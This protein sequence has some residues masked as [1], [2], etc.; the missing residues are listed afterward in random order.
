MLN[1]SILKMFFFLHLGK[2]SLD[3][4]ADFSNSWARAPT[5]FTLMKGNAVWDYSLDYSHSVLSLA[6]YIYIY[7]HTHTHT[8]TYIYIYIYIYIYKERVGVYKIY[9][10]ALL[11]K[12]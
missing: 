11:L 10:V 1:V 6:V 8:H 7:T 3:S 9:D 4:V 5:L 2:L 12:K